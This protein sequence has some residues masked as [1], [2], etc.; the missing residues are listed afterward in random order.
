MTMRVGRREVLQGLGGLAGSA[1]LG[2]CAEAPA[3]SGMPDREAAARAVRAEFLHAWG[4]YKRFA[5]G[6]DEV[7]PVSGGSSAFFFEKQSV[8]LSIVEALDTLYVME[9]DDELRLGVD[10]IAGN[11]RFDIDVDGF[12]IFEGIIRLVGG[13]LAGYLA[14]RNERLLNKARELADRVMPAFERSPTGIPYATINLATG[15]VGRTQIALAEAGSNL[16]EFGTL[17]RLTGDPRYRD[18]AKRSLAA[19]VA[20]RSAL[21]LLGTTIDC[22]TGAW[23]DPVDVSIDQPT[24]SFYE[25]LWGGYA[26]FGDVD[27]L[28]WFRCL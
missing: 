27:C 13:L 16:L 24:D 5:F 28:R 11:L 12:S 17:S 21:D 19:I 7:K 4:G 2:S 9:L 14:V 22:E 20:R 6:A 18:A 1:L 26:L 15:K 23:I 3:G 8:G 10:W 25:Y